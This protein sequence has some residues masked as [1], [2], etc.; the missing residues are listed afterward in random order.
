MLS[1]EMIKHKPILATLV[2]AGYK[3]FFV[4]G[5]VRD[6][7]IGRPCHDV[8]IT[9]SATPDQVAAL[10]PQSKHVGAHYGVTIVRL[11][12]L[13]AEIATFRTDG[14]YSDSR[15]PD[16]VK[17]TTSEVEDVRRRDFT[18]NAL[19]MDINGE[20][21]DYVDGLYDLLTRQ[22]I[23]AINNPYM[24]FKED[25]LRM[26][27]AIRFAAQLGFPIQKP[28]TFRAIQMSASTVSKVSGERVR[29]ELSKILTCGRAEQGLFL[30][31]A[32]GLLK[33]ILPEVAALQGCEQNAKHHPEGDVFKHT[34]GL[35]AQLEPGCSLTLALAALL[36]DIG[37]P[38]TAGVKDG[39]PTFYGHEEQSAILARVALR[40]LKF[41]TDV[42][43]TVVDHCAQHMTVRYTKDMRPAKLMRFLRQPN[44]AE[45]LDLHRLDASAG[46]GNLDH[47]NLCVQKLAEIPSEVLR[48]VRF[49]TGADLIAMGLKP[50]PKF[51]EILDALETEQLEGRIPSKE[52]AFAFVTER[53]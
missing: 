4:G 44:F 15:R 30:L 51:K 3:A 16:N 29:D 22:M 20:V 40:R 48:P 49:V 2:G 35:L 28:E 14:C 10:F 43:E 47:Y 17:F 52:E 42:I 27:R 18:I 21:F 32:S 25:A 12:E 9:T 34:M 11:G 50:G 26:L 36:H 23:S 38:V 33:E 39:Q 8:D 45:L 13:E 53:A 7:L 41:P 46:S 24:R 31:H 6:S 19:L 37:K 1:Q 5:C